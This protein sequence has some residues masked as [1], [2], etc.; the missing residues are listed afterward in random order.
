MGRLI[1]ETNEVGRSLEEVGVRVL[2]KHHQGVG[3]VA[4]LLRTKVHNLLRRKLV[5][6]EGHANRKFAYSQFD[7]RNFVLCAERK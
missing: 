7:S 2:K 4:L 3:G 6:E 1:T 5:K